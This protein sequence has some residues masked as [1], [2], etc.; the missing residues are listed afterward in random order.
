MIEEMLGSIRQS[1]VRGTEAARVFDC[2]TQP[3][4]RGEITLKEAERVADRMM[5]ELEYPELVFDALDQIID[6]YAN[7]N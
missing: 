5:G 1:A 3:Y 4:A 2:I 7:R 6:R